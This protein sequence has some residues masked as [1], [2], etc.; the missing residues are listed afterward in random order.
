MTKRQV[1]ERKKRMG[2]KAGTTEEAA[3]V[4]MMDE[5]DGSDDELLGSEK[6]EHPSR[7]HEP[8]GV[9]NKM[10]KSEDEAH[11]RATLTIESNQSQR[12]DANETQDEMEMI[13]AA[14]PRLVIKPMARRPQRMTAPIIRQSEKQRNDRD[15]AGKK[16]REEET[17]KTSTKAILKPQGPR[18]VAGPGKKMLQ[19]HPTKTIDAAAKNSSAIEARP[20]TRGAKGHQAAPEAFREMHGSNGAQVAQK[21]GREQGTD[22]E[23]RACKRRKSERERNTS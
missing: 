19:I 1:Q 7:S 6:E 17:G 20:R 13:I 16:H 4:D 15:T 3:V 21:R 5:D 18:R 8:T 22:Q 2:R 11:R 10:K 14:T 9:H 12:E 23:E